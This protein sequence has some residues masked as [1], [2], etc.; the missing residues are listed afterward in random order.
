MTDLTIYR[1]TRF[2]VQDAQG[3]C[4]LADVPVC[5]LSEKGFQE[6]RNTRGL[7]YALRNAQRYRKGKPTKFK[8]FKE[9]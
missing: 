4:E 1:Y 5:T 9:S 6:I 7:A 3:S 8:G 2:L